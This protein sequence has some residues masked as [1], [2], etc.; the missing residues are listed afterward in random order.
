MLLVGAVDHEPA[1][2]RLVELLE[3]EEPKLYV[4]A[5]WALR[6]LAVPSTAPAVLDRLRRE[7]ARTVG[8]M[9][10]LD[11]QHAEDP[12][13]RLEFPRLSK[14]YD[15]LDQLIQSVAALRYGEAEPLLL[16]YVPKPRLRGE[17]EPPAVDAPS[18]P[19]LRASALWALGYL[20][21]EKPDPEVA[22]KLRARLADADP[23][24]PETTMVRAM[25]AV[26]LGRMKDE[27]SLEVVRKVHRFEPPLGKLS[28]ACAWALEQI[29]GKPVEA[30]EVPVK[31]I[32]ESGWFLEPLEIPGASGVKTQEF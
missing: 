9:A 14:T 19:D 27:G 22:E 7:T 16:T 10:E 23:G 15:Q 18:Q 29:T 1:A 31:I 26:G 25:A 30:P 13:A 17:M 21:A 20:H 32:N 5:A 11:R 24:H 4:T 6:K 3:Y 2:D 12:N 28:N 8:I